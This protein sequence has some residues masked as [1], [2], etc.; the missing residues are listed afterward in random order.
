[1][2]RPPFVDLASA[3]N[4]ADDPWQLVIP[5]SIWTRLTDHLFPGDHDEHG[6]VATAGIARTDRGTR[7]L[8]RELFIARD[9]E[10]FIPA[11]NAHRRLT[12]AF[13]NDR[14]RYCRDE[15]LAYLAIHN[16]GGRDAVDFS[17]VDLRSHERGYPALL[18]IA[19]GQ[20]VGALVIA[21]GAIAGDI[22]TP[23]GMRRPIGETVIL[24]R[25]IRRL[26]PRPAATPPARS[27]IDDRQA[28][29][30]GDAGQTLLGRLK[31]GVIGAGGVGLPIVA[32]IAR[33]GVR[34]IVVVDPDRVDPTNLPRLPE[35]TRW[36]AMLL[37]NT[38][39]RPRW[40]RRIGQRMA[41]P[42]VRLARRIARRARRDIVIDA[43][44]SDV[45]YA[46]AAQQLTD[47]DYLF[48]AADGHLARSIFNAIVHQ[49]LI[50]G[51]QLGSKVEL[52]PDG[53]IHGIYSIVRPVTPDA[54]CLWCNGLINAARINDES[55]PHAIREAQRYVPTDD[56]P[57]PSIG[58]LNALG[59]AQA[60]NHFMLAETGLLR[61][62]TTSH[63]Y[64]RFESLTER[65]LTEIPRKD[66]TCTECGRASASIRARG[67]SARLPT[68]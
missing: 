26:Y 55:L 17:D 6:A 46:A 31:V 15:R 16:H 37:L 41:T 35:S 23:D 47:C 1:M 5:A 11:Q 25:N 10:E 22:W 66:P 64:R 56:A 42:K 48:L 8:V 43:V 13:V 18:D 7:L 38:P 59:V 51:V 28:R 53:Y 44:Q 24:G 63:D 33:L 2:N 65:Q 52:E 39:G 40:I 14:I 61:E 62:S 57:A 3:P 20:P 19:R 27:A 32:A 68:R 67:D 30:Y 45:S 49:Y 34:H 58:T 12:P 29:I 21:P 36:D 4:G 54:G 60:T 9:G 50:P